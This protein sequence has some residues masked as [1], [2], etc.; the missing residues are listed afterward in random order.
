MT[1]AV[2]SVRVPARSWQSE[3]R[4][5]R[6]VWRRDLIRFVDEPMSIVSWLLQPL[7]FLLVLGPG[8]DL[9]PRSTGGADLPTFLFPGVI[10]MGLVY[11]GMFSAASLVW[12]RELGF[13]RELLVAPIARSSIVA[14]KCLGGTTIAVSQGVLLLALAGLVHVPY[15]PVLLLAVLALEVL[16]AFAVT[17]FGVMVVVWIRQPRTFTSVMQLLVIPMLFLSGALYPVSD[18]PGWL[19]VLNRLNP[20]T[21]AVDPLRRL[22]FAHLDGSAPGVTW[23]GWTVPAGLEVAMVAGMAVAF[24]ALAVT[25]FNRTE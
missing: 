24:V 13:L 9:S 15:D 2:V 25:R 4:A 18:L 17:A 23:F 16:V 7:L 10:C 22:V 5:V 6:T 12:D 8:L 11:S 20:L 14:G 19:A 21:Y 1:A 3:L